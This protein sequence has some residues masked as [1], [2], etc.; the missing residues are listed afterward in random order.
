MRRIKSLVL[1][2]PQVD[3]AHKWISLCHSPQASNAG[4]PDN[5]AGYCRHPIKGDDNKRQGNKPG[6]KQQ[7][8]FTTG[9]QIWTVQCTVNWNAPQLL[10]HIVTPPEPSR[11]RTAETK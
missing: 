5:D 3:L 8:P 2:M 10:A 4:C 9:Q 1:D 11:R 6:H 7:F